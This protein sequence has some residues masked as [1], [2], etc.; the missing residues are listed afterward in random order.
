MPNGFAR[1]KLSD[2]RSSLQF[3][4]HSERGLAGAGVE[5]RIEHDH[6]MNLLVAETRLELGS[7][8]LEIGDYEGGVVAYTAVLQHDPLG[9]RAA[10]AQRGLLQCQKGLKLESLGSLQDDDSDAAVKETLKH[11]GVPQWHSDPP[12]PATTGRSTSARL[13]PEPELELSQPPELDSELQARLDVAL[14]A[15]SALLDQVKQLQGTVQH[16]EAELVNK[17]VELDAMKQTATG[18]VDT[19]TEQARRGS[20]VPSP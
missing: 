9:A 17:R 4:A 18:V 16:L 2:V 13:E 6:E 20:E 11:L 19:A 3:V 14:G 8:C 12:S 5:E 7:R 1:T 10:E 15:R